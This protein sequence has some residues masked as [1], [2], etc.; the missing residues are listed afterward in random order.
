MLTRIRNGQTTQKKKVLAPAS[1]FRKNVL[2]V[3]KT[4]NNIVYLLWGSNA[5]KYSKYINQ[6]NNLILQTS[7][8]SPLSAYRGFF[9]SKHFSKCNNYLKKNNV[10]QISW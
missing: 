9:G 7:H 10:K 8:P 2:D 4:K 5:K 6:K 1:R 3:L